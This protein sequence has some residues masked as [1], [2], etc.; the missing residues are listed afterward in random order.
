[1]VGNRCPPYEMTNNVMKETLLAILAISL[2]T[3]AI[4]KAILLFTS[5]I[6]TEQKISLL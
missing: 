4:Q 5:N 6:S 2:I 3:Q 1:M